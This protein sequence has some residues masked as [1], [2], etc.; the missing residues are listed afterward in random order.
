MG[1]C[2]VYCVLIGCVI[3]GSSVHEHAAHNPFLYTFPIGC[4]TRL[5]TTEEEG[6]E[7]EEEEEEGAA[8]QLRLGLL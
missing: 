3:L 7:L 5:I 4:I 2:T 6:V 8:L 1:L